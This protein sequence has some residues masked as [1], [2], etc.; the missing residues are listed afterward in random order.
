LGTHL[1]GRTR[2]CGIIGDPI[3]HTLSPRMHNAAFQS[4]GLDYI[5]V[6]FRVR[7]ED[8]TLAIQGM[9]ALHIRGLSVTI[10][11]KVAVMSLLD[12]IDPLA[13][14]IGA[15]N[16][17]SNECGVLTGYNTD[18]TGFL[19]ALEAEKIDLKGKNVCILGAGGAARAIA[20][21]VADRG[22][23]LTIL[24]RH[25]DSAEGLANRILKFFRQHVLALE[26]NREN[27]KTALRGTDLL[28][29]TTSVGMS[30]NFDETPVPLTLLN[31]K[32]IIFDIIY[33]PLKTRLLEG[34]EKRGAR[35]IS[36]LQ[37]L[38][39]QGAAAFELWTGAKAPMERMREATL[40]ALRSSED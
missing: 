1:S 12:E 20:F 14:K 8:L 36:G 33:N 7:R 23:R 38:V 24:N 15:V 16:T 37:M 6:P 39:W 9:R 13:Q 2:I 25:P 26:L 30:P 31:R 4:A 32:L 3:E 28:V 34:A 29:N 22:A 21:S 11:H 40:K 19:R 27:L 18:S 17:V 35:V 10:P 5:Y